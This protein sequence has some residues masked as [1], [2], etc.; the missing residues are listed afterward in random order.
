MVSVVNKLVA[1]V[2]GWRS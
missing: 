2:F 1:Q